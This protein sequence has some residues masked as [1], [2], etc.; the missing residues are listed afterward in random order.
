MSKFRYPL[1]VIGCFL[2]ALFGYFW[3]TGNSAEPNKGGITAVPSDAVTIKTLPPLYTL[4]GVNVPFEGR[5]E[6]PLKITGRLAKELYIIAFQATGENAQKSV[7]RITW[8]DGSQEWIPPGVK[9][10]QLAPDRKAKQITV[11][12]Y[13]MHERRVFKDSPQKGTL[14]WE[15]RY[16]PVN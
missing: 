9:D 15:V 13:S 10:I 5:A 11:I 7:L 3:L 14:S 1:V 12:G 6:F 2:F 8:E 4:S 16:S